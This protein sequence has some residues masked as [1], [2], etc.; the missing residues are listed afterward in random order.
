VRLPIPGP[1][2]VI[3]GAAAA[4]EAV[5]TAI[6]LVPRAA[7]AL[8]RVEALLDRVEAVVRHAEQ[9]VD[10]SAESTGRVKAT[11]DAVGV[12]TRDAGRRVD[13]AG[14][15]IDRLDTLL[16]TWEPIGRRLAPQASRFADNVSEHEVDA[17]VALVDRLPV[18]LEHMDSDLLPVLTKLDQVGPDLHELLAV[19]EDLRRVVTGLPGVG[20]LRRRGEDEPP[21]EDESPD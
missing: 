8:T 10:E 19:V 13:A 5:E 4:A 2:A 20:L 21:G 16:G 12:V 18:V 7:D 11:V 6:S 14:G 1:G 9:V 15:L 3:G 17:A